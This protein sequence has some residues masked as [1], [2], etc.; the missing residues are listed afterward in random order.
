M[1]I[2]ISEATIPMAIMRP[3]G[4]FCPWSLGSSSGCP[5]SP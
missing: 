1:A 3:T 4:C 5:G 2:P